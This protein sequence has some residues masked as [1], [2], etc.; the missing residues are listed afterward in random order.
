MSKGSAHWVHILGPALTVRVGPAAT[1]KQRALPTAE[2]LRGRTTIG[3]YFS[4]DWCNPCTLFTPLLTKFYCAGRHLGPDRKA[5]EV[6]L[7]SRC[8]SEIDTSNYFATMPWT[9]M[10]HAD[11]MGPCGQDLM[12][13]LG[14]TT[15]PALVIL[16]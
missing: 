15:I 3:I 5:F 2:V 1:G 8:R 4:A 7:V 12:S 14:V 11:A 13:R 9:A 6:V 16:N 10:A